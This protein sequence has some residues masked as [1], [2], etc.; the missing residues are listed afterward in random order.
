ML[1][2]QIT[3]TID[4]PV[5]EVFAFLSDF[6]NI[7]RWNYYVRRVTKTSQGPVTV[8]TTYHQVRQ[9]DEQDFRVVDYQPMHTVAVQTL[10]QSSPQFTRR[11]TLQPHGNATEILDEWQL[12]TGRPALLEKLAAGK[13]KSAVAENLGKL[14]TLLERGSVTLQDGRRENL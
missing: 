2:F 6:E 11:F 10:P 14:K 13:V 12:D 8:G 4:R 3:T 5:A 7:P 9:S 1:Q